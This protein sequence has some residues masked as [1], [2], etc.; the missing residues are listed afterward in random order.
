MPKN[1]GAVFMARAM[2]R[3]AGQCPAAIDPLCRRD[4]AD[5]GARPV[6][7]P[8]VETPAA[9]PNGPGHGSRRQR[10]TAH[11]RVEVEE[12]RA[13]LETATDGVVLVSADGDIAR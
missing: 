8:Q 10:G 7:V 6:A 3:P 1:P 12:L 11:L 13:I 2:A 9:R 4:R 5:A